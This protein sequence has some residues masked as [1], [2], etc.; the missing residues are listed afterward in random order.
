VGPWQVIKGCQEGRR[1]SEPG[2]EVSLPLQLKLTSSPP[3]L[4]LNPLDGFL[5]CAPRIG[6]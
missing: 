2:H 4:S 1:I 5:K 6:L 3:L